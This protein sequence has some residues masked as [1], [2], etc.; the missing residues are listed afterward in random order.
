MN[1]QVFLAG[2]LVVLLGV[3]Y[4]AWALQQRPAASN[5]TVFEGARLIVGDGRAAIENAAFVVD[6]NRFVQ[7]GKVGEV[8]VPS[9]AARVSLMGK[10]VMPA[11]VD[12]HT[13]LSTTREAL[14]DDLKRRAY[15]GVSAAM[16]L[17]TDKGDLPFQVRAETMPGAAL[18]RTAG[19]GITMP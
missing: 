12:T 3:S 2:I 9:G 16:S 10:T 19:R 14:I 13:H 18:Y 5:V 11:I 1:R 15:Y 8:R 17:G 7:V 6:G 4:S